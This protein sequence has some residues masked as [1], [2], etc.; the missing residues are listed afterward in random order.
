MSDP[1]YDAW[2]AW[3]ERLLGELTSMHNGYLRALLAEL[4]QMADVATG[5]LARR[6][7]ESDRADARLYRQRRNP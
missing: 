2:R 4:R 6:E 1:T 3:R 7:R 5:E